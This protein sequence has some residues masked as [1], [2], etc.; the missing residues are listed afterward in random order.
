MAIAVIEGLQTG[1]LKSI[2]ERVGADFVPDSKSIG[3]LNAI[4][5]KIGF[6]AE[7]LDLIV[8]PLR[9]LQ[10]SRGGSS[11]GGIDRP[12]RPLREDANERLKKVTAAIKGLMELV[13]GGQFDAKTK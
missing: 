6:D 1:V 10:S 3:L 13:R 12:S 11:H 8:E 5:K 9:E 2:A 4:L 7:G